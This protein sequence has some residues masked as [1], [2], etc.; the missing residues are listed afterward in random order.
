MPTKINSHHP[1]PC[2][3]VGVGLYKNHTGPIRSL[4]RV[5]RLIAFTGGATRALDSAA[6]WRIERR[7]LRKIR[8][9]LQDQL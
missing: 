9:Q 7:A 6:V 2:G 8:A 1:D 5:G 4:E 3:G